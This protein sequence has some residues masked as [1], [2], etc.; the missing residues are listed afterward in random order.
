[1]NGI[2]KL[3]KPK[4]WC[5][6]RDPFVKVPWALVDV[7]E[8]VF[9]AYQ[10]DCQSISY[11]YTEPTIFFEFAYDVSKIAKKDGLKNVFVTNGYN[12]PP[13]DNAKVISLAKFFINL[14]CDVNWYDDIGFTPLHGAVLAREIEVI[15]LLIENGADPKLKV[16]GRNPDRNGRVRALYGLDA[17]EIVDRMTERQ[18]RDVTRNQILSALSLEAGGI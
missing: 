5:F 16:R 18:L 6:L 4:G 12:M 13:G 11:T 3:I 15:V 1:M 8:I 2:S 10:R 14:G 7:T 9:L 17:F